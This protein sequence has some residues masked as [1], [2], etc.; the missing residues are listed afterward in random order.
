V[1]KSNNIIL[2]GFPGAGKSDTAKALAQSLGFSV[3]DM[4]EMI[5]SLYTHMTGVRMRYADIEK[6][7]GASYFKQIERKAFHQ[8]I[9]SHRLVLATA[10]NTPF[11]PEIRRMLRQMGHVVF[12]RQ[13]H[14]KVF[15]KLTEKG[16]PY[17]L[18]PRDPVGSFEVFYERGVS[19]F[20]N[21]A[22]IIIWVD[23]MTTDEKVRKIE[24]EIGHVL[25]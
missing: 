23:G 15:R 17:F 19:V 13:S 14:E 11:D 6:H 20:Q 3:A 16:T 21:A 4:E 10:G 2:I 5:E 25:F 7:H 24:K 12:L 9:G 18:D 8:V 1:Y 22:E